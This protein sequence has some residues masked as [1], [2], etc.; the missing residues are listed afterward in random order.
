MPFK[1]YE[2]FAEQPI[3]FPVGGKVYTVPPISA[4]LGI[5][6]ASALNGDAHATKTL[7]QGQSLWAKLLGPVYNEMLADDVP[8]EVV[9]RAGFAVLCDF[10]YDREAAE[11][12]WETNIDP[13]ARAAMAAAI[14]DP[15]MATAS[16]RSLSTAAASRTPSP[17]SSSGTS[18]RT[19]A[20]KRA[21]RSAGKS[22]S[23]SGR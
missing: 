5:L 8:I 15:K 14:R 16:L 22:S 19:P 10:Q 12:V 20:R 9:G 18:S 7:G 1:A 3:Q 17:A 2:E 6:L 13:E 4:K 23:T 11:R 21:N